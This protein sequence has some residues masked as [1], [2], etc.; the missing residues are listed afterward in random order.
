MVRILKKSYLIIFLVIMII[1]HT[2]ILEAKSIEQLHSPSALPFSK[3]VSPE[4][5]KL[6]S[7]YIDSV[8]NLSL[9]YPRL[10]SSSN[11]LNSFLLSEDTDRILSL[12]KRY[13]ELKEAYLSIEYIRNNAPNI[14][15]KVYKREKRIEKEFKLLWN[16]FKDTNKIPD[17]FMETVRRLD[18]T[19]IL[20]DTLFNT[21]NSLLFRAN[22]L[23]KRKS[24]Y[25]KEISVWIMEFNNRYARFSLL[26][27]NVYKI[28]KQYK[29]IVDKHDKEVISWL[30]D[31]EHKTKILIKEIQHKISY[32]EATGRENDRLHADLLG[33]IPLVLNRRIDLLHKKFSLDSVGY[34][35]NFMYVPLLDTKS[36]NLLK[37]LNEYKKL[38]IELSKNTL[39]RSRIATKLTP[40]ISKV[41]KLAREEDALIKRILESAQVKKSRIKAIEILS[42][43]Q[44]ELAEKLK[45]QIDEL[46]E[47]SS[48]LKEIDP[49]RIVKSKDLSTRI[50]KLN[51]LIRDCYE[52]NEAAPSL[53]IFLDIFL[54][55][56]KIDT[57]LKERLLDI[58]RKISGEFKR[59]DSIY[60]ALAKSYRDDIAIFK[61]LRSLSIKILTLAS[62]L[63]KEKANKF[64]EALARRNLNDF[65]TTAL[66]EFNK[67]LF[68]RAKLTK[69]LVNRYNFLK[70]NS[71]L[72]DLGTRC[73]ACIKEFDMWNSM[74]QALGNS[75][76]DSLKQLNDL[77]NMANILSGKEIPKNKYGKTINL[78][79]ISLSLNY[80]PVIKLHKE[81]IDLLF[82]FKKRIIF[83][84]GI[85]NPDI[86]NLTLARDYLI[87]Y[88]P[89]I[90]F[91]LPGEEP[92]STWTIW[93][94]EEN[95]DNIISHA[96]EVGGNI[97]TGAIQTGISLIADGIETAESAVETT[98][99]VITD[100]SENLAD[101]LLLDENGNID[102][103]TLGNYAV[104]GIGCSVGNPLACMELGASLTASLLNASIE[105]AAQYNLIS[106]EQAAWAQL[107]IDIGEFIASIPQNLTFPYNFLFNNQE[108]EEPAIVYPILSGS[109]LCGNIQFQESD[110]REP[111]LTYA[112]LCSFTNKDEVSE[113]MTG[114]HKLTN[115]EIENLGLSPDDFR[116]DESGFLAAIFYNENTG[117]YVVAF[118]GSGG[119][120][121]E[122][123]EDWILTDLAQGA[124]MHT[125]QYTEAKNLAIKVSN[126]VGNHK[127]T[128]TGNSLG[129]GLA[130][131]ASLATGDPAVTF[132]RAGIHPNTITD[133][134]LADSPAPGQIRN[135]IVEGELLSALSMGLHDEINN[136]AT[137]LGIDSPTISVVDD[138]IGNTV[139]IDHPDPPP[140]LTDFAEGKNRHVISGVI[141][142]LENNCPDETD[143]ENPTQ[144]ENS[145]NNTSEPNQFSNDQYQEISENNE[146][147]FNENG[148]YD[149]TYGGLNLPLTSLQDYETVQG[150]LMSDHPNITTPHFPEDWIPEQK[151]IELRDFAREN[152]PKLRGKAETEVEN[153]QKKGEKVY[154]LKEEG[155]KN[156]EIL[157]NFLK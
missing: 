16:K 48:S 20:N 139:Y 128:F 80:I 42:S 58:N 148:L 69:G 40:H 157:N 136:M 26:L 35:T 144:E 91:I 61:S 92:I 74:Q 84:K 141:E 119:I 83:I 8:R 103:L 65:Y 99:E 53:K 49:T 47:I 113:D 90:G 68:E 134:G 110:T 87:P 75:I 86:L 13:P 14:E 39:S 63:F 98:G 81:S 96:T 19:Y 24:S 21:K 131:T 147:I 71:L 77:S 54:T 12:I 117:E 31:E 18:K 79:K 124:G 104:E 97:V 34:K 133:L 44:V 145:G 51:S 151:W 149:Y 59:M 154:D 43:K 10:R 112:R 45:N 108:P 94:G 72:L 125:V 129:G 55:D 3:G 152:I 109:S 17:G 32:L 37:L 22:S 15:K 107:G 82:I 138:N 105:T 28:R 135:Y 66:K 62:E 36:P 106:E 140:S 33:K 57:S 4:N 126:A 120:P 88:P 1:T 30:K 7:T 132:N 101:E 114:W 146:S 67:I 156:W 123:L 60:L 111:P 102:W 46:N 23:L 137:M 142:A 5:R 150:I 64:S 116:D 70:D 93:S 89:Y 153:L 76:T 29:K 56:L 143:N 9:L 121:D 95:A 100:F 41:Q 27:R 38:S 50:V 78:I 155:I 52:I 11:R 2:I 25:P 130:A 73:P 118:Q 127:L 6:I 85:G 115:E 122:L